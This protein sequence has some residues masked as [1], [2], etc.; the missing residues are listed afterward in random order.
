MHCSLLPLT[1]QSVS[2]YN[3]LH[4]YW[5]FLV[6][7][8]EIREDIWRTF[9]INYVWIIFEAE[10]A[11]V[12]SGGSVSRF[13]RVVGYL[14]LDG[15]KEEVDGERLKVFFLRELV[16]YD[17]HVMNNRLFLGKIKLSHNPKS[18]KS[19]KSPESP[20]SPKSSP[21][22]KHPNNP[23]G[24]ENFRLRP[25]ERD[26]NCQFHALADQLNLHSQHLQELYDGSKVRHEICEWL[27]D[28]GPTFTSTIDFRNF[29]YNY[30]SWA[31]YLTTLRTPGTWGDSLTLHVASQRYQKPIIVLATSGPITEIQPWIPSPKYR[32]MD[33]VERERNTLVLFFYMEFHYDSLEVLRDPEW[34]E[35]SERVSIADVGESKV[36]GEAS[37]PPLEP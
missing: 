26:G 9:L 33:A 18:P 27:Q 3:V 36:I 32:N 16:L 30:P 19:P 14:G 10:D 7:V 1:K 12:G 29:I 2:C 37:A 28:C 6:G 15:K 17:E 34:V 21:L 25:V 11:G 4:F 22:V 20:K 23:Y 31:S 13:R 24:I 35:G 8:L 5:D